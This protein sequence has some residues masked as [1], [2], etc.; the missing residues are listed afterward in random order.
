MVIRIPL[1]VSLV[2]VLLAINVSAQPTKKA[3][4]LNLKDLQGRSIKLSDYRSKVVLINFWATWCVPCST[5]IPELI[6]LQ[7]QYRNLGL[8][9]VGI[10]YPPQTR[11]QVRSFVRKT[12]INYPVALGTESTKGLFDDSDV[13]PVTVVIDREG[14]ISEVIKGVLYRDEFE[15]QIKPLLITGKH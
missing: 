1:S 4:K 6:K 2:A 12:R 7:K 15:T 11:T 5:E 14:N 10:T 3:P 13:L 8:R 9:I